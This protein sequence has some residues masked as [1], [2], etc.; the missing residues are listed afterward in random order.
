MILENR[1]AYIQWLDWRDVWDGS[2]TTMGCLKG[3]K[4]E[5]N[6]QGKCFGRSRAWLVVV[7]VVFRLCV[8][9]LF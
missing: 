2:E 9:I 8:Y 4:V 6:L 7:F 1:S 5:E 3:K